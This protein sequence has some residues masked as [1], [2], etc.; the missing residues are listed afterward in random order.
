MNKTRIFQGDPRPYLVIAI[1]G[2]SKHT[3]SKCLA[4]VRNSDGIVC[5]CTYEARTDHI[6][7]AIKN[8]KLHVCKAGQPTGSLISDYFKKPASNIGT[9]EF[10]AKALQERLVTFIGRKNISMTVGSSE[11]LYDLLVYAFACG[12]KH[13]KRLTLLSQRVLFFLD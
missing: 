9:E 12:A 3:K 13:G 8:G 1:P 7:A 10:T 2:D 6:A 5:Q 11:E 4:K